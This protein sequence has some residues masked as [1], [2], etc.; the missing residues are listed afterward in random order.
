MLVILVTMFEVLILC[1][2]FC[3]YVGGFSERVGG[4]SDCVGGFDY[5]VGVLDEC[6][7]G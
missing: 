6:T 5:Y 3:Y 1:W 2:R 7:D 4:F